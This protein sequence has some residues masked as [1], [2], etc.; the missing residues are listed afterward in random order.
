[1]ISPSSASKSSATASVFVAFVGGCG[2]ADVSFLG[3][4]ALTAGA[5]FDSVLLDDSS[6]LGS[7]SSTVAT[8]GGA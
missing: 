1:M 4:F 8:E 3:V 5:G 6:F 7:L 2:G